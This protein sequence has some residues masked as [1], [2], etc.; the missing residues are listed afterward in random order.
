LTIDDTAAVTVTARL[1]DYE[2]KEIEDFGE[3]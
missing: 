2:N 3:R 1:Y